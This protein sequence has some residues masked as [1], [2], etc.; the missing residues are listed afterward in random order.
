MS[1]EILIPPTTS[2]NSLASGLTF[3][4]NAKVRLTF[5]RNCLKQD[6]IAFF[7]HR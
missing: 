4:N 5:D 6:K 1:N 3:V 7:N 2:D